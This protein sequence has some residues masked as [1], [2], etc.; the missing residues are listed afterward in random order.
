MA[1]ELKMDNWR[2]NKLYIQIF[3]TYSK[4]LPF[5]SD[6]STDLSSQSVSESPV[7]EESSAQN[8]PSFVEPK[9]V[10]PLF[11]PQPVFEREQVSERNDLLTQPESVH[12]HN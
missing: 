5:F 7:K 3:I 9:K 1:L 12:K 8:A 11:V 10:E 4:I 2:P 6:K